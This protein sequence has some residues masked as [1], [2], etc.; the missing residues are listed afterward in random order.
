VAV[1]TAPTTVSV[2]YAGTTT[3]TFTATTDQPSG[4]GGLWVEIFEKTMLGGTQY[5][6]GLQLKNGI[7]QG[8]RGA[9]TC[10]GH[11]C[12]PLWGPSATRGRGAGWS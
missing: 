9:R 3:L 7:F 12:L 6:G 5:L 2:S 8:A 11:G 4:G 10:A 1:L